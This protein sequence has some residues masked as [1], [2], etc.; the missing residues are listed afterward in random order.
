MKLHADAYLMSLALAKI[1]LATRSGAKLFMVIPVG[2][3]GSA[4]L[5]VWRLSGGM[6]PLLFVSHLAQK[7]VVST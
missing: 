4:R 2:D 7:A 5:K 3:Y 6:K 1:Q